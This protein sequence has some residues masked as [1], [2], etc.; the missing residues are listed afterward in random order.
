MRLLYALALASLTLPVLAQDAS[1]PSQG[2]Y[3]VPVTGGVGGYDFRFT[4]RPGTRCPEWLGKTIAID[5]KQ[6]SCPEAVEAILRL[7]G[8]SSVIEASVRTPVQLQNSYQNARQ[9]RSNVAALSARKVGLTRS[10]TV[11]D[12]L[13]EVARQAQVDIEF[14]QL[15]NRA[16]RVVISESAP[17]GANNLYIAG[18]PQQTL[19]S[20][21]VAKA[22]QRSQMD[23]AEL[24]RTGGRGGFGGG[25][26]GGGGGR[27]G[28]GPGGGAFGGALGAQGA[29]GGE[30]PTTIISNTPVVGNGARLPA[31][32]I[33]EK[34]IT[35]DL[36]KKS[37]KECFEAVLKPTGLVYILEGSFPMTPLRTFAFEGLPLD[38]ALDVLCANGVVGWSAELR[39]GK[40]YIKVGRRYAP[41]KQP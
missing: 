19:V 30:E 26:F 32:G 33:S 9:G 5:F 34:L 15:P 14:Y 23:A 22:L 35:V 7:G 8:V 27:G 6:T 11:E 40:P 41:P 21:D 38:L 31:P 29:R 18:A 17:I 25:G 39:E 4:P 24:N 36:R 20:G 28:A 16:W 12:A 3:S 2:A 10:M 13:Q 37:L 1:A